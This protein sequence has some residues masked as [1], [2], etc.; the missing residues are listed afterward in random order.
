MKKLICI[1][2]PRGCHLE[3]DEETLDVKGNACP[4]G[5]EYGINEITNPKRT[6]TSTVKIV[7]AEINRLPVK[8]DK[9]IAK[10]LMFDVMKELDKICVSH[11]ITRGTVIIS[12]VLGSDVNIIACRD[13]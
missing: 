12:N 2:C 4:R 6:I 9:P 11:P 7:G 3:I 5:K 10:S 13:L 1:T 8:T